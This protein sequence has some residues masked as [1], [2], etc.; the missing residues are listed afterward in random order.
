MA[1]GLLVNKPE[2]PVE[3]FVQDFGHA[4]RSLRREPGFACVALVTLALGIGANALI[5][6]VVHAVL[7]R[8]LPFAE[9]GELVRVSADFEKP[10][11]QDAGLSALEL[12]DLQAR[13]DL[14]TGVSGLFP[15]SANLTGSG[16]P[17]R[18]ETL[19][20]D[21]NYFA[22]LGVRPQLGRLF[23]E[24]DFAPGIAEV[25]VISD[26]LWRRRFGSDP[27]AVGKKVR[28][29]GDLFTIVGVV[30]R[31]FHHPGR[32]ILGEVEMWAPSGW[33]ASPY[34][35]PNRRARFLQGALARLRPGVALSAG[36]AELEG[37]TRSLRAQ[38]PGDYPEAAGWSMRLY[39][40]Q[41]DLVGR[42]RPA[43]LTL[44]GA[45]G[46]VLLIACA[47]VA[48]LLL[49]RATARR[50]E[51]AVRKAL[52]AG[53]G[54]LFRQ[55]ATEAGVLWLLGGA[56]GLVLAAYGLPLLVALSPAPLPR[57]QEIELDRTVFAFT[58]A[59]S[60]AC[61][62]VCSL[63]PV[64]LARR[65]E[66]H[67]TLKESSRTAGG[68]R[69]HVRGALVVAETALALVLL[70]GAALLLRSAARLN[71]V[72]PGFRTE[73]IVTARLWLPQP[74]LP[75]TG[76][77][78]RH[79]TRGPFYRQVLARLAALPGVEAAAGATTLPLDG[80]RSSARFTVEG[81]AAA[82]GE[83]LSSRSV[84]ASPGYFEA[85]R[86]PVLRGRLFDA[87]DDE[88]APGVAL[89]SAGFARKYFP[90]EEALGRR[91]VL[92]ARRDQRADTAVTIVGIVGDVKADGLDVE[93]P[94]VLYRSLDQDSI[95]LVSLVLRTARGP[96]ALEE[97]IRREV[98][99][100]DAD[101]PVYGVRAFEEMAARALGPRRFVTILLGLFALVSLVL[102]AV[103]IYGVT[104][105]TVGRRTGEIG[106]RMALGARPPDVL[107]LVLGQGM[108]LT[109]LGI[110]LGLLAAAALSRALA[111]L[112]FGVSP[113]DAVAF[114]G[115]AVLLAFVALL[116]CALPARRAARVDPLVALREE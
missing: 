32:G 57:G 29:D 1:P 15:I 34:P 5:F 31:T 105:Y 99:Q 111:T 51:I 58:A 16:E 76:A 74:N 20:V 28:V 26:G 87:R 80:S 27:L 98:G 44:L 72:D 102:A 50:R 104:A 61:G 52:G 82:P 106:L 8:P 47:N 12:F 39:P 116:A 21:T 22:L 37:L 85:L 66:V 92:P 73:G 42:V 38:D 59:L 45:V 53:E 36:R 17:E 65:T 60:L 97:A 84:I 43:L 112:L 10:T 79:E 101:Q 96:A 109:G 115:I 46:F 110:G 3:D 69:G 19:L 88:R 108:A 114:G 103:G 107:R 78:F 83:V 7:L 49:V 55:L 81:R 71:A 64:W 62:L 77:Y 23:T 9:A 14:F 33:K 70:V 75:E 68:D 94:P 93:S 4:L 35:E 11:L 113:T 41:D 25:A 89:V 100:I 54:R 67:A 63:F 2:S 6:S 91:L 18:V 48:N 90:G 30:S 86:I 13:S 56:A 95:L 24:A 40:L